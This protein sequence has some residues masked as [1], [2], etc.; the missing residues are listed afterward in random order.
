MY[1]I[2][3]LCIRLVLIVGGMDTLI[4]HGVQIGIV[5]QFPITTVVAT[6]LYQALIHQYFQPVIHC[7]YL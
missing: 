1:L 2:V 5:L 3:N 7:Q 4:L 6:R